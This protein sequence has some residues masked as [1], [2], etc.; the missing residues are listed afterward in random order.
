MTKIPRNLDSN[1]FIKL[2]KYLN[3]NFVHQ[4]G[5]HIK[6][7]KTINDSKFSISLPNHKPLK[8]GTLSAIINQIC[9]QNNMQKDEI[10]R[11][12]IDLN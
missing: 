2:L 3:Y 7:S 11:I 9:I 4:R 1:D 10:I 8:V 12:V 6:F 5:S